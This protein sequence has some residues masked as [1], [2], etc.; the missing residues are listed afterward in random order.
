MACVKAPGHTLEELWGGITLK[1][2]GEAGTLPEGQT[3]G[4]RGPVNIAAT[5]AQGLLSHA[6]HP[7][8]P[9]SRCRRQLWTRLVPRGTEMSPHPRGERT[10]GR[11]HGGRQAGPGRTPLLTHPERSPRPERA[12]PRLC[13]QTVCRLHGD[14]AP[15][16]HA[17]TPPAPIP[18]PTGQQKPVRAQQRQGAAGT[19]VSR[20]PSAT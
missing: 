8:D 6:G 12:K 9:D 20:A 2:W 16:V 10:P 7:Q 13:P 17:V 11:F 1:R 14:W 19:W 15:R 18:E 4:K 5:E 3:S